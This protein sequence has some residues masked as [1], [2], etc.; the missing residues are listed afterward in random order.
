LLF[1]GGGHIA[2]WS[3]DRVGLGKQ[4]RKLEVVE[5]EVELEQRLPLVQG[6][7]RHWD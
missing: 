2:A 4:E 5:F 1:A 3:D 7:S 6:L